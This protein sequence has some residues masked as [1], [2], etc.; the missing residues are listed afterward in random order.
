MNAPLACTRR[1]WLACA[2]GVCSATSV[3]AQT[4][5]PPLAWPVVRLIDGRT[6]PPE[7]W[8][9]KPAMV[10][11]WA[12][13]CA[14]CKRHNA[15]LDQ[16][17]ALLGAR[18]P[19]ILGVAIDGDAASVGRTVAAQGWRFPVTVDDGRLR[20]LFTERRMVPM[21]CVVDAE[22][23]ITQRIPGEM[24]EG[25]VQALGRMLSA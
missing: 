19:R 13:W 20:P 25:D 22:G 23:L 18:G 14:Y 8:L 12:T 7:H 16:L 17:H 2:A 5:S 6:L 1:A 10:V 21:T 9:G 4:A 15:R 11:F 24:A 3:W